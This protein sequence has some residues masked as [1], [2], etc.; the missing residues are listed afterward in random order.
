[1]FLEVRY[2]ILSF[3][4]KDGDNTAE[5]TDKGCDGWL[6]TSYPTAQ[7]YLYFYQNIRRKKSSH[8]PRKHF[9]NL[10]YWACNRMYSANTGKCRTR[11]VGDIVKKPSSQVKCKTYIEFLS[12]THLS[13][14][15]SYNFPVHEI[16][17]LYMHGS[18]FWTVVSKPYSTPSERRWVIS[19]SQEPTEVQISN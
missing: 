1:M 12:S 11:S 10:E 3:W 6:E 9:Q 5:S 18:M 15:R 14:F 7:R 19:S 16:K 8:D 17:I 2:R 13:Y 4:V